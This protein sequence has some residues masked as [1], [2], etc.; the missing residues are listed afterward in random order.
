MNQTQRQLSNERI[1]EIASIL[2]NLLSDEDM[3]QD[4]WLSICENGDSDLDRYIQNIALETTLVKEIANNLKY[5]TTAD[6]TMMVPLLANFPT[7][8]QSVLVFLML[9]FSL[10]QI[11]QYKG[12]S[13]IRLTQMVLC[14]SRHKCWEKIKNDK[15]KTKHRR[16][17]QSH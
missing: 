6:T 15:K 14:I 9:S 17:I 11:S 5:L 1:K 2:D 16:K 4:V 10:D 8:E 13:M 7:H 3:R 12:I